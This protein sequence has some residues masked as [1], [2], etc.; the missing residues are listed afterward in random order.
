MRLRL[1]A[2]NASSLPAVTGLI[3]QPGL[4]G[5]RSFAALPEPVSAPVERAPLPLRASQGYPGSHLKPVPRYPP[6][7]RQR[8]PAF[9]P[10]AASFRGDRV[11]MPPQGPGPSYRYKT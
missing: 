4:Q 3:K 1:S 11:Y 10:D 8:G 6:D 2:R 7:P 5:R 9:H